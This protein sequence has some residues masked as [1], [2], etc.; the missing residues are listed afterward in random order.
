VT[1][2][3]LRHEL[4]VLLRLLTAVMRE[5]K[6]HRRMRHAIEDAIARTYRASAR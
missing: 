5:H 4:R 1:K 6:C 2:R 3:E